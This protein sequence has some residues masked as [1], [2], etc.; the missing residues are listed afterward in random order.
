M[1]RVQSSEKGGRRRKKRYFGRLEPKDDDDD[2]SFEA[3]ITFDSGEQNKDELER[4]HQLEESRR[5]IFIENGKK[6]KNRIAIY[7]YDRMITITIFL[8]I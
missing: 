2:D 5:D 7:K 6:I 3:N 8:L 4:L 1:T